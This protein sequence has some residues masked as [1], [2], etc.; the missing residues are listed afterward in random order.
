LPLRRA[1]EISQQIAE[2]LAAAHGKKIVHRDVKPENIFVTTDGHAKLLDFGLARHNAIWSDGRKIV[3]YSDRMG[4][5]DLWIINVDGSGL[6]PVT[7]STTG[8][9][10]TVVYEVAK[11]SYRRVTTTGQHPTFLR[12]G[13]RIAFLDGT[14]PK[15]VDVATGRT[16]EILSGDSRRA[17]EV[18]GI[19][20]DD[21][22]LF[23]SWASTQ[24]DLWLM[25]LGGKR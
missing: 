7:R 20:P 8:S 23:V 16:S 15:I 9:G 17:I 11:K 3:S 1:L 18:F 12:D 21:R 14:V 6:T 19:A 25:E 4:R 2:G 5:Y 22:S 24:A 10:G 13:R